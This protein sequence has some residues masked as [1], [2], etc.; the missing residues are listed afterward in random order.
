MLPW[1]EEEQQFPIN[2]S[3]L[4]LWVAF[5]LAAVTVPWDLSWGPFQS[6]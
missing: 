6:S 4:A 3:F 5:V 2:F 1:K